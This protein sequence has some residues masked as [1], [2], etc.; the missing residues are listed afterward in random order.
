MPGI[1][2]LGFWLQVFGTLPSIAMHSRR[3]Q[4]LR[5]KIKIQGLSPKED[6]CDVFGPEIAFEYG[7]PCHSQLIQP[8]GIVGLKLRLIG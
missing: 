3:H 5:T 2:Q 7:I 8:I 4:N 6:R 1:H